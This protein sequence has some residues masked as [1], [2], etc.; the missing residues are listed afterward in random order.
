MIGALFSLVEMD[1]KRGKWIEEKQK[2]KEKRRI[3]TINQLPTTHIDWANWIRRPTMKE[4]K[5]P[6]SEK[7]EKE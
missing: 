1:S 6:E 3:D 2:K 7:T 4:R 5:E